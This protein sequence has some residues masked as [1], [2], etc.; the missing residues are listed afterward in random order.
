MV[1]EIGG[2]RRDR[3][4]DDLQGER[5]LIEGE[6]VATLWKATFMLP[7]NK[8]AVVPIFDF[9]RVVD[10]EIKEIRPY[11]DPTPLKAAA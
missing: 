9:F 2:G 7:G 10:G 11:F 8:Q 4:R 6:C 5:C 1:I 3:V